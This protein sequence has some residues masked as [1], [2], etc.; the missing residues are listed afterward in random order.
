MSKPQSPRSRPAA[1]GRDGRSFFSRPKGEARGAQERAPR[2]E[3]AAGDREG[4]PDE[5]RDSRPTPRPSYDAPR[6][7]GRGE[8]ASFGDRREGSGRPTP[9][10]AYE[11]G[12]GEGRGERGSYGSERREGQGR[13]GERGSFNSDRREGQGRPDSRQSYGSQRGEGRGGERGSFNSDRREGYGRPDSRP[14]SGSQR[15]EGRGGERG[16]FGSDRR[17]GYG[18]PDSRPSYDSQRGEGR[19]GER[20]SFGSDRREGYGRPDSR[21]S[22]GS[23]RGEGRGGE[24]GSF[25]SDRREGYGRPDSRPS[26]GAPRGEGRDGERGAYG[27]DRREGHGQR[28]AAPQKPQFNRPRLSYA[29]S[30]IDQVQRVLGEILQWTYPADAALSH[31]LRGHPGLGARDRSEV[32]EAVYDVLRHLRRYRQFGES[33]VGPAS[34]RLAILGLA[35]TLGAEALQEGLDAAEAEWLQRVLQIDLAT[36]P[37]AVRGSIPDWLDERLGAMESPETLIE[38]LNRQASLDLRVN[39]LKVER[40][41][42]LTELQQSAGRYEPVAMPYSPWGIRME[43]RPAINRWPQF[44]NGSIE[45]QDEGSQ[46]LALL[47][48]PRRGEMIIDFCAGAGGKTLLLGALMRSTG[49]LYAFDVSAARLARAKPRFARSGLSNVVPVAIDSENDARVKRLAGKAQRVLVDAPCS[50]I[51][52]LRRNPDLKWRQHP[53]SLAELGQLQER[54]LN[55]AARCVAPGGRLVYATCS[56]LAEE[57]EVQADRF[58]ASH[59]DFERVDAAEILAARCD[60]LKLEGPYVQLRPDV[61]GTDGFFAAVFER[62]KKGEAAA[63]G[64]AQAEA[65]AAAAELTEAGA[66]APEEVAALAQADAETPAAQEAGEPVTADAPAEAAQD[67]PA[68]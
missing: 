23:Q 53:E 48:A 45:V 32:A 29:A 57:N 28:D 40:D 7:E 54:I 10:P 17:E 30:R 15:G 26:H 3:R 64:E 8:R 43:G 33:G 66:E 9:R 37:R 24:R 19:G 42:M 25:G 12:R 11:G 68:A 13:G 27:S 56:L 52:T 60:N 44:E 5:R 16:S 39:P 50:G 31:W 36:L 47:V 46:L 34:R 21:P 35:A 14:S 51:G 41:A 18:R 58:L 22:Y 63:E 62:R 2:A 61:H 49:R 4:R 55:S 1:E 20:G 38:A 65:P 6:G 67:K 59:P